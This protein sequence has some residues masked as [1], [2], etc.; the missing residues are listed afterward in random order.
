MTALK[1][2]GL[3]IDLLSMLAKRTETKKDDL[4]ISA[5]QRAIS[6]LNTVRETVVTKSQL[7]DLRTKDLW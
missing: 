5:I 4:I 1:L 7:E 6:E 2:I 3:I